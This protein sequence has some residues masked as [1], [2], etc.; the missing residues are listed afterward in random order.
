MLT[1]EKSK[2]LDVVVQRLLWA[3]RLEEVSNQTGDIISRRSTDNYDNLISPEIVLSNAFLCSGKEDKDYLWYFHDFKEFGWN[4]VYYL[5]KITSWQDMSY[6]HC[7]I[8]YEEEPSIFFC[9]RKSPAAKNPIYPYFDLYCEWYFD[10]LKDFFWHKKLCLRVFGNRII[11]IAKLGKAN[12][13]I[14][15][16]MLKMGA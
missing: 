3:Y 5:P 1:L 14:L 10:F 8:K 2:E 13:N 16:I 15:E 6:I 11:D 7:L 4:I 12:S 9:I